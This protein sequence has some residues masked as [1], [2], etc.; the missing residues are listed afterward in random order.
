MS[1]VTW[2]QNV[3]DDIGE[4]DAQRVAKQLTWRIS[5]RRRHSTARKEGVDMDQAEQLTEYY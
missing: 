2:G 3:P 5:S 1:Y 4:M